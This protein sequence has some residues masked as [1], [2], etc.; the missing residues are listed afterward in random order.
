MPEN[1]TTIENPVHEDKPPYLLVDSC[2]LYVKSPHGELFAELPDSKG[3]M[4]MVRLFA[5]MAT[6][7]DG[8][9]TPIGYVPINLL[10]VI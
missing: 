5:Q 4:N 7:K 8:E 10:G 1:T 6:E 9:I 2:R 3:N